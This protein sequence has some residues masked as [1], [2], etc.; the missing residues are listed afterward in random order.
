VQE[1]VVADFEASSPVVPGTSLKERPTQGRKFWRP[2]KS[3]KRTVTITET[4]ATIIDAPSLTPHHGPSLVSTF[5]EDS[6][7]N[8]NLLNSSLTSFQGLKAFATSSNRAS[9]PWPVAPGMMDEDIFEMVPGAMLDRPPSQL[10]NSFNSFVQLPIAPRKHCPEP[11]QSWGGAMQTQPLRSSAEGDSAPRSNAGS[12][13]ASGEIV[14]QSPP[15]HRSG[16]LRFKLQKGPKATS[17]EAV[18]VAPLEDS[19]ADKG[20]ADVDKVISFEVD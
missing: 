8:V 15:K 19:C 7:D 11:Q 12:A 3:S 13:D 20:C 2:W 10:S 5:G 4:Q 6:V 18:E 17:P 9:T 14:R 16:S 1:E